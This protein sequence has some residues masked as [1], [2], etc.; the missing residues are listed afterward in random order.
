MPVTRIVCEY[1]YPRKG[2]RR[3]PLFF[4]FKKIKDIAKSPTPKLPIPHSKM[5]FSALG[6]R[7]DYKNYSG[8]TFST[9]PIPRA[10]A[11]QF[12]LNY[13]K[14]QDAALRFEWQNCG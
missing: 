9:K 13:H 11:V 2:L 8:V 4:F 1:V 6:L 3:Y 14:I 10:G 5:E 12:G 7:P